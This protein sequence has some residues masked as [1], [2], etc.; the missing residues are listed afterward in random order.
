MIHSQ[1]PIL[2]HLSEMSNHLFPTPPTQII[3]YDNISPYEANA[4]SSPVYHDLRPNNPVFSSEDGVNCR[5]CGK[6]DDQ[7]F[8][9]GFKKSQ[10][11]NQPII[12]EMKD[13]ISKFLI[14]NYEYKIFKLFNLFFR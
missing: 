14:N 10:A 7:E 5:H 12:S 1:Q 9:A 8:M 2:N 11:E 4:I 13:S 6:K 3:A